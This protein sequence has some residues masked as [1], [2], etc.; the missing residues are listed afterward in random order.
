MLITSGISVGLK[1]AFAMSCSP[2]KSAS[3]S[4]CQVLVVEEKKKSIGRRSWRHD[5]LC[6]EGKH[7]VVHYHIASIC[8]HRLTT[9]INVT[10]K[11]YRGM[12][13]DTTMQRAHY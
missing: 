8:T 12:E 13:H 11:Q 10:N 3:R 2:I 6:R 1:Q 5:M 4:I 9:Y 7:V